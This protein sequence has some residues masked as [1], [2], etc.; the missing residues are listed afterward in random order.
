[1][2]RLID[3][4]LTENKIHFYFSSSERRLVRSWN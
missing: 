2:D 1:M 4:C 3:V